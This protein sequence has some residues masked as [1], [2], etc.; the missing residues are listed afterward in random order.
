LQGTITIEFRLREFRITGHRR[1]MPC[2]KG[3]LDL[4]LKV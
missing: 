2:L 3:V 4:P 1:A